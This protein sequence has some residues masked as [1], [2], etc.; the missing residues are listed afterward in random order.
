MFW[1]ISLSS[2]QIMLL[3]QDDAYGSY[4]PNREIASMR[5][6]QRTSRQQIA[7]K[8]SHLRVPPVSEYH[9]YSTINCL[10]YLDIIHVKYSHVLSLVFSGPQNKLFYHIMMPFCLL[11]VELLTVFFSCC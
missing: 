3:K 7:T 4:L 10:F 9:A 8:S 2:S 1:V 11:N 6:P 5:L